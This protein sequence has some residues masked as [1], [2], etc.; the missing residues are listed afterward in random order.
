MSRYIPNTLEQHESIL[1]DIKKESL[2]DL[3]KDIPE[4]LKQKGRLNIP[5]AMSELEL[6]KHMEGLATKNAST[7]EYICFLGAGA[8]DHYIPSVIKHMLMRGEF[9]TAYT[10]YQPEISQGTL[11]AIFEYQTMIC[12][13]TGMDVSNASMY[14]GATAAAEAVLLACNLKRRKKALASKSLHP[15]FRE[16]IKTY[17]AFNG[18]EIEEVEFKDGITDVNDLE[19]K[20]TK[21]TAAFVVQNPNFFGAIEKMEDVSRI[22]KVSGGLFIVVVDPVSLA[23]LKPPAE[24]DAD[25][26][27]GEGQALGNPLSFGGPY[28]GFFAVTKDLMRRMPGRIVGQ[29]TDV[30]GNRGFVLTMQTREQHIRREKATSNICTNQALNALAATIYLTIMGKKGLKEVANLCIQKSHYTLEK[31]IETGKFT[32]AFTA[33]FFKEF[34]VRIKDETF[35]IQELNK[36][37]LKEKIIGGYELGKNYAALKDAWLI[38]VTEKRTKEE[39]DRLGGLI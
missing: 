11:Q 3:F 39:I 35:T 32:P 23:V 16:V 20:F 33:P 9:Y 2:D 17:A 21:D 26:V 30:Y 28:L 22:T 14:D 38:A 25:I 24:F 8:Y 1:E 27:I 18:I 15:E 12:E 34:V 36:K 7:D 37:L 31:L 4:S 13:L 19:N 5:E 29:T 10:P 6:T